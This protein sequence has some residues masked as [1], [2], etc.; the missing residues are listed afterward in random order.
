MYTA[1]TH[2]PD[3]DCTVIFWI[4]ASGSL[5]DNFADGLL[6]WLVTFAKVTDSAQSAVI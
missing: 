5:L 6:F 2:E 1:K 3:S 4:P